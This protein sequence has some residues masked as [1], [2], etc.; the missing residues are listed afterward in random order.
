MS[1][2]ILIL[3]AGSS[4]LKFALFQIND[5]IDEI[6]KQKF[7]GKIERIGLSETHFTAHEFLDKPTSQLLPV[8][9]FKSAVQFLIEWLSSHVEMQQ[10]ICIG[11]RIVHGMGHFEAEGITEKLL[12]E[13]LRI[14]PC[15]PEHL[16]NEIEMIKSFRHRF[17]NTPQRVC[18]DTEFHRNMPRVAKLFPIPRRF[19]T[20]GIHRYGFHGLSFAYLMDE[21]ARMG[22]DSASKGRVILAH[23]GNGASLAAVCDGKSID[24]TM[25]FTPTAGVPMSTRSGDLDPG[26]VHYLLSVEKISVSDFDQMVNHESGLLGVSEISSDMR[27]LLAKE[28]EDVRA[29][30]AVALFCYQ[31]KKAIGS[32][33]AA[34]CGVDTLIFSGGIGENSPQVRARVCDGLQFLGIDLDTSRN[35]QN[36][37]IISSAECRVKVYVIETNEELMIAK[38]VLKGLHGK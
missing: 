17:P 16:P 23:L 24:T 3:N 8:S 31:V 10:V 22:D 6:A 5:Q 4:S 9:D 13:L 12:E 30:E 33:A 26:L 38:S 27:D 34:L 11:H 37:K 35:N 18:Y 28:N 15:D 7:A 19:D 36:E 32:F 21:L 1:Q 29:G 25:G 20:K 14:S 2:S